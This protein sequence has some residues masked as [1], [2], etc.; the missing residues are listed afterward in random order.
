MI[1]A[2]KASEKA[3]KWNFVGIL[4]C[5]VNFIAMTAILSGIA[6]GVWMLVDW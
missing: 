5:I 2:Q 1:G 3:R 6:Y 4:C